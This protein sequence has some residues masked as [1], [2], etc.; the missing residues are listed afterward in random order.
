V[1]NVLD[2][3]D[4]LGLHRLRALPH[5]KLQHRPYRVVRPCRDPHTTIVRRSGRDNG[6]ATIGTPP[7]P[8]DGLALA[9]H[10]QEALPW[11]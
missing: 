6:H 8:T 2:R 4:G 7:T 11:S 9:R 1:R 3:G 5:G 10:D